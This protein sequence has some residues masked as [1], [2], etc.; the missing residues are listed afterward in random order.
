VHFPARSLL[1][2]SRIVKRGNVG[3]RC[4]GAIAEGQL[5]PR[6][7]FAA[8]DGRLPGY[9]TCQ[10]LA[11][12]S[13]D[14]FRVADYLLKRSFPFPQRSSLSGSATPLSRNRTIP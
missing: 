8:S 3:G 12:R 13:D 10:G 4:V 14:E 7:P 9:P 6:S 11:A 1:A 2:T 5:S